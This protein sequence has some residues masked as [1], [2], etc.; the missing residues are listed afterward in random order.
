MIHAR[1]AHWPLTATPY[2]YNINLRR[3]HSVGKFDAAD[4]SPNLQFLLSRRAEATSHLT[5]SYGLRYEVTVIAEATRVRRCPSFA[6]GKRASYWD[7]RANM[8]FV[9]PATALPVRWNGWG[10][11]WR[12]IALAKNA[13][14]HAA[15]DHHRPREPLAEN[16]NGWYR[17]IQLLSPRSRAAQSR[18]R[19]ALPST[20]C[21]RLTTSGSLIFPNG[22]S[23]DA[24]PNTVMDLQRYQD[25]VAAEV[26]GHQAQ[27]PALSAVGNNFRNGYIAS[28]TLSVEHNFRDFDATVAYVGTTGIHLPYVFYP[29]SYTGSDPAFAPFTKFDAAGKPVGGASTIY[30]VSSESHSSY[31]ALQASLSKNSSRWGTV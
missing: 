31:N 29:N 11:D 15:G 21:R 26:P 18:S 9:E 7:H 13:V 14:V 23:T 28:W 22:Q 19:T 17:I 3:I 1:F 6:S 5:L 8:I 16:S 27:L 24:K 12:R 25:A 2:S 20:P 10:R 30:V 4:P